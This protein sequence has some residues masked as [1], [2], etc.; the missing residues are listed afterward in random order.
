MPTSDGLKCKVIKGGAYL[1]G[2]QLVGMLL[3]LVS[4]VI[5]FRYLG[6][7]AF[8]L[9]S[10][11]QGIW[12][13]VGSVASLGLDVFLVREK[14]SLQEEEIRQVFTLIIL[15][16]LFAY[17]AVWVFSPFVSVWIG[18]VELEP[19]LKL[20]GVVYLL[21]Q[22]GLVSQALLDRSMEFKKVSL[23]ELASQIIYYLG[24]IPLV[25][26][27]WSYWGVMVGLIIST[28]FMTL[29]LIAI[30]SIRPAVHFHM[31]FAKRALNYGLGYQFA[32][33]TW[34]IRDFAVPVV[35]AKIAGLEAAGIVGAT[36]QL[37]NRVSFLRGVVWR[38]SI[39]A[40][41][42]IYDDID[43]MLRAIRRGMVYQSLLLGVMFVGVAM[44]IPWVHLILGPKWIA[45]A[46]VYPFLAIGILVNAVFS[47]QCSALF[48][49]GFNHDVNKFHIVNII[50]LLGASFLMVP[51]WGVWGYCVAELIALVSYFVLH[52]EVMRNLGKPTYG[53]V[54]IVLAAVTIALF[55]AIWIPYGNLLVVGGFALFASLA[56]VRKEFNSVYQEFRAELAK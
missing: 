23:I 41:A 10:V 14:D 21:K 33:W 37:I 26:A 5:I 11:T 56:Q 8:G 4:M 49:K 36:T 46:R 43:R 28:A 55:V 48:A 9:L 53:K 51:Y 12:F 39:A 25:I 32:V 38:I 20:A 13:F 18:N 47:L 40:F 2:R 3:S 44:V 50:I 17:L 22:I 29:Y 1:A 30:H 15:L 42:K 7:K 19:L 16:F 6:P 34:Q 52:L 27:G 24:A 54:F 31:P 35:I 45:V